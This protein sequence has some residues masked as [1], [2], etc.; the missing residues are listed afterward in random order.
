[1]KRNFL[2]KYYLYP[3]SEDWYE[4]HIEEPLRDLVKIL[5]NY[6]IN[7]ECSCGHDMYI[8][9]QHTIDAELKLIHDIVWTYLSTNKLP[10]NFEIEI[11]HKVVDGKS[12]TSLDLILPKDEDF[13]NKLKKVKTE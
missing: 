9:C 12:S 11:K 7:T 1:M 6:G 13:K 4:H 10:V 5:R 8:Q 2:N 3:S